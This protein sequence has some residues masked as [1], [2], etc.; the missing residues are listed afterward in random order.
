[1]T[2]S[3]IQQSCSTAV[4]PAPLRIP[5]DPP[6]SSRVAL[7]TGGQDKPYALGLGM[8]LATEGILLDFIGSNEVDSPELRARPQV[9]FLNLRGDQSR[10]V[11]RI[12]KIRR[13]LSYYVRL[14]R[15]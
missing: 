13:V 9:Q 1:M 4:K 14:I 12:A 10:N 11:S 7:L 5:R 3:C 15:Y 8:A 2:G 6:L